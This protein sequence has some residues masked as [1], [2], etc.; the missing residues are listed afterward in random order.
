MDNLVS[1][2]SALTLLG[3]EAAAT[4]RRPTMQQIQY[5]Q[6]QLCSGGGGIDSPTAPSPTWIWSKPSPGLMIHSL[7]SIVS[8]LCSYWSN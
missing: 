1:E 3:E 4:N 5:R 2:V 6:K 8:K 7:G